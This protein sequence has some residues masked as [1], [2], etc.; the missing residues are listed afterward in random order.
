MVGCSTH[1]GFGAPGHKAIMVDIIMSHLHTR[2]EVPAPALS[3]YKWEAADKEEQILRIVQ[4]WEALKGTTRNL[5]SRYTTPL[6]VG[7]LGSLPT[8]TQL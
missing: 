3:P 7:E 6:V 2:E 5:E 4:G 8:R 1:D